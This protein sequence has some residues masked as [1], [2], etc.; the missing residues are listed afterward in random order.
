MLNQGGRASWRSEIIVQKPQFPEGSSD[1]LANPMLGTIGIA[2]LK[3]TAPVKAEF[4]GTPINLSGAMFRGG[5]DGM[6][7]MGGGGL[8]SIGGGAG[9]AGARLSYDWQ[10][11]EGIHTFKGFIPLNLMSLTE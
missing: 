10:H 8:A 7:S 3:I 9:Y 1:T 4:H 11:A 2:V 5:G 6:R